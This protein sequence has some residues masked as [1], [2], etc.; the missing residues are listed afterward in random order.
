[1]DAE[2]SRLRQK[3]ENVRTETPKINQSKGQQPID[4]LFKQKTLQKINDINQKLV[5]YSLRDETEGIRQGLKN[6]K[7]ILDNKMDMSQYDRM[8]DFINQEIR[9]SITQHEQKEHS[10]QLMV[11]Q[12]GS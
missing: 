9:R 1:M 5:D 3:I 10:K 7:K 6:I 2:V 12:K 11:Q 8:L 4:D